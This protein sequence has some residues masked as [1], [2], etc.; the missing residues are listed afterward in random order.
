MWSPLSG[1]R[2]DRRV[3]LVVLGGTFL[4]RLRRLRRRR[5]GRGVAD[6]PH[7]LAP[8]RALD[9]RDRD[10]GTRSGAA[11]VLA[12][13]RGEALGAGGPGHAL[14]RA[15]PVHRVAHRRDRAGPRR[16][17]A[18]DGTPARGGHGG[19]VGR[20]LAH[21]R[22]RTGAGGRLATG[23]RFPT[24]PGGRRPARRAIARRHARPC[25]ARHPAAPGAPRPAAVA[26]RGTPVRRPRG[27]G[28]SGAARCCGCASSWR[29]GPRTWRP[30]PRPSR[31]RADVSSTPTTPN[32][33][34]W[35]ATSTTGP[36]STWSRS[37]ST[38]ASPTP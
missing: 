38:S 37:S 4:S 31:S 30:W 35:N 28:G 1:T 9:P 26:G 2:R 29:S 12:R 10:R 36:S 18:A 15:Q 7:R 5:A 3:A 17:P 13:R 33:G 32:G 6:R 27:P 25:A 16:A 20:G 23:S 24:T 34:D 14:R 19:E 22:R 21:G 8:R 11:E